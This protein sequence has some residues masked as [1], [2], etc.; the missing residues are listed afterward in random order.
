IRLRVRAEPVDGRA[1]AGLAGYSVRERLLGR[2]RDMAGGAAPVVRRVGDTEDLGDALAPRLEE[3]LVGPRMLVRSGRGGVF[4]AENAAL[5]LGQR[6]RASVAVGGGASAR[7]HEGLRM[8]GGQQSEE[9]DRLRNLH[10][11][12]TST[13]TSATARSAATAIAV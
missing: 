9:R 10:C 6:R 1:V 13:T 5:R 4:V 3:L 8:R 2:S 7:A 12:T 11:F